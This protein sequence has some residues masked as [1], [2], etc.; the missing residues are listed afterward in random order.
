M[1][2]TQRD[3]E[4]PKNILDCNP[5]VIR[6]LMRSGVRK[7]TLLHLQKI[8]PQA[9]YPAEIARRIDAYP[10]SVIGAL[11]GVNTRYNASNSLLALGAVSVI[12]DGGTI[13]YKLSEMGMKIAESLIITH[14]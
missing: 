11:K 14:K 3:V 5:K 13:Y 12:E 8:Y 6:S 2:K 10:M 7:S 4:N 9:S 1:T